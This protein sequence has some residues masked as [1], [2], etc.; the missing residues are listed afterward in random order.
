ML[1]PGPSQDPAGRNL[2]VDSAGHKGP[3]GASD[4]LEG[5]RTTSPQERDP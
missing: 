2:G 1:I 5:V 3:P 4:A